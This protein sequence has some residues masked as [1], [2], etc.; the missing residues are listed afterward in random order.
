MAALLQILFKSAV[1][2]VRKLSRDGQM[3]RASQTQP[4]PKV[5]RVFGLG[6]FD[7][8][9]VIVAHGIN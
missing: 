9:D 4:K 3:Y 7:V 8:D 1:E 2:K 5:F 6:S